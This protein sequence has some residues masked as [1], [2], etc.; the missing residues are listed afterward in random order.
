VP[1]GAINVVR[2]TNVGWTA[3]GGIEH[4]LTQ[5]WSVNAEYKYIDLGTRTPHFDVPA[6]LAGTGD[7]AVKSNRQLLTL[8]VNY[9]FAGPAN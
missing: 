4:A 9:K 1:A 5:R 3:G 7:N 6:A 8:G 2:A